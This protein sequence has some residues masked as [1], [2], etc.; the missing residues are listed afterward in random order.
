MPL[1]DHHVRFTS[2]ETLAGVALQWRQ[3]A[4]NENAPSINVVTFIENI[5][6]KKLKKGPF[7]IKFFDQLP[8]KD[9]AFVSFDPLTLNVDREIWEFGRL[10]DPHASFVLAH[11]I[12]HLIF[13]DNHAKAF[14]DDSE[15]QVKFAQNEYS[16]EWQANTFAGYFLLPTHIVVAYGNVEDLIKSCGARREL[17]EHRV[18]TVTEMIKPRPKIEG[19][20]CIE[21]GEFL[22]RKDGHDCDPSAGHCRSPASALRS[23]SP[24]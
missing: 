17:A 22:K 21:C 10:G 14:S 11:E 18:A 8:E 16:A 7:I 20:F 13:H 5:L 12:G 2:E 9:P 3:A 1:R 4:G 19:D 6:L 24:Q 15:A 23:T